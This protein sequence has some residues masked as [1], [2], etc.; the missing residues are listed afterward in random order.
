VTLRAKAWCDLRLDDF[1]ED[2]DGSLWFVAGDGDLLAIDCRSRGLVESLWRIPDPPGRVLAMSSSK[3]ACHFVVHGELRQRWRLA[4]PDL[5]L[6]ARDDLA[7]VTDFP[8]FTS[9]SA[10]GHVAVVGQA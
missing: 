1:A 5:T 7:Y 4:L 10:T 8:L 3:E 6:R 9:V 2:Y